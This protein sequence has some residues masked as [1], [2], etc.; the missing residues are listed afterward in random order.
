[1]ELLEIMEEA[2]EQNNSVN[3]NWIVAEIKKLLPDVNGQESPMQTFQQLTN[4][5]PW[6]PFQLLNSTQVESETDKAEK[7]LFD[8]MKD[9]Y[10]FN[11][12]TGVKTYKQTLCDCMEYRSFE[13][14]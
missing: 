14:L 13:S 3:H 2:V 5:R 12:K 6:I 8:S 11:A 10:D 4:Q 9:D 1:M 7:A